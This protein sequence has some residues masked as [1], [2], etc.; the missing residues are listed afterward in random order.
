MRK[1]PF[2]DLKTQYASIQQEI[3]ESVEAVLSGCQFI[4]GEEVANFEKQFAQFTECQYAIG[5]A[6]GLDA[7]KLCLRALGIQQG[8][9]VIIPAHTFI[10][11]ALAISSVGAKPVLVDVHPDFYNLD[12]SHLEGSIN[13]RT[14][15]IL[16]VH[17]YGQACDM[18]PIIGLAKNYGLSVIEDACQAH[19]ARYK[20]QRVGSIG[21]MA[22]FSFYPRKNLGAYGDGGAVTTNNPDLVE[23]V[24]ALRNYGSLVRY[25]HTMLG[26]NSRLDSIQAAVLQTKLRYLSQ[27]N[28][29][30]R[31]I[32]SIYDQMLR[33]VGDLV[34]PQTMPGAEHVFHLYVIRTQ[35]RDRLIQHLAERGISTL[36]HYPTPIHLQEAYKDAGWSKDAFPV[37]E[38]LCEEILSL[39]MFPELTNDQVEYVSDAI[40]EFF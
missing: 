24:A 9:E 33:S 31:E 23:R 1:V 38:R 2:L 6:S 11:T 37:T 22:A 13:S 12:T 32:A 36:I 10:A 17:L 19:G 18:E 15:A 40:A 8:D 27:W 20:G 4:L 7:L 39:P 21:E 29:R 30:R 28:D 35:T 34:L 3:T 14:K 26:E 25:K 5:V 16:P